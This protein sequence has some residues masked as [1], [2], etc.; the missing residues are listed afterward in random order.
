M[1]KK[2]YLTLALQIIDFANDIVTESG[3]DTRP[4]TEGT[5]GLSDIY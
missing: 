5:F 1:K 2:D 3:E 4:F